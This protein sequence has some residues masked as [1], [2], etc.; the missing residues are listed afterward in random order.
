[1]LALYTMKF[2]RGT[3]MSYTLHRTITT[4]VSPFTIIS[5]LLLPFVDPRAVLT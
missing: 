1:M 5:H 4:Q 3:A 2:R